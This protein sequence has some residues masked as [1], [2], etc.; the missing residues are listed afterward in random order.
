MHPPTAEIFTDLLPDWTIRNIG[1]GVAFTSPCGR[2]SAALRLEHLVFGK[3]PQTIRKTEWVLREKGTPG[4]TGIGNPDELYF[5]RALK[6]KVQNADAREHLAAKKKAE[7]AEQRARDVEAIR[8]MLD[9]CGFFR[10]A[11][12]VRSGK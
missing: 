2:V 4:F 11:Y 1:D 9:D 5:V 3:G 6:G 10:Y 12:P 7:Q 8:G